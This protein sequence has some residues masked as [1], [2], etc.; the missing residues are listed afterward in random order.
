MR[1]NNWKKIWKNKTKKQDK[2]QTNKKKTKSKIS[3][4]EKILMKIQETKQ[5]KEI[6]KDLTFIK[7]SLI[8]HNINMN[9]L[10]NKIGIMNTDVGRKYMKMAYLKEAFKRQDMINTIDLFIEVGHLPFEDKKEQKILN[11]IKK[12]IDKKL[13]MSIELFQ[14]YKLGDRL[15][16]LDFYNKHISNSKNGRKESFHILKRKNNIFL[17]APTSAG[18]TVIVTNSILTTNYR[19]IILLPTEELALQVTSSIHKFITKKDNRSYL[20]WTEN[21]NYTNNINQNPNNIYR[22]GSS[23][24]EISY[25]HLYNYRTKPASNI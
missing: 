9:E 15:P 3:S 17:S 5:K 25:F 22:W 11:K 6:Q 7:D 21:Y 4:K 20:L 12:K 2:K 1:K 14:L 18:K 23:Y 13:G 24:S 19:V 8:I 10:K 16:P